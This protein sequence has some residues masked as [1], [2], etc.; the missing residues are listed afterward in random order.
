MISSDKT[1]LILSLTLFIS[2]VMSYNELIFRDFVDYLFRIE[3]QLKYFR[4]VL[5]F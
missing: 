4:D 2:N 3:D 5:Y 1:T